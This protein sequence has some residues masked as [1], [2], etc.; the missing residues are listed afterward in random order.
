MQCLPLPL[1]LCRRC[2]RLIAKRWPASC[3]RSR[4]SPL[5]QKLLPNAAL[6]PLPQQPHRSQQLK[7][8]P[9]AAPRQLFPPRQHLHLLLLLLP[10]QQLFP[11]SSEMYLPTSARLRLRLRLGIVLKMHHQQRR[12]RQRQRQLSSRAFPRMI[13]RC[14]C[15]LATEPRVRPP[16]LGRRPRRPRRPNNY[17]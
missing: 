15:P 5:Q 14:C 4:T 8:L 17:M 6:G 9:L 13:S 3:A 12:R 7:Q 1:P 11:P 10:L 16:G 2:R